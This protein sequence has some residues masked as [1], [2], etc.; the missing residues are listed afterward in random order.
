MWNY[1]RCDFHGLNEMFYMTPLDTGVDIFDDIDIDDSVEYFTDLFLQQVNDFIPNKTV[2]IRPRD[3]PWFNICVTI[4]N[5]SKYPRKW[6]Q[7]RDRLKRRSQKS[8][9][10]NH[11]TAY[12]TARREAKLAIDIAK[13]TYYDRLGK[14]LSD[15]SCAPKQYWS[16]MKSLYG[17]KVKSGIPSMIEGNEIYSTSAMQ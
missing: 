14:K 17:N 13:N 3:K 4:G 15:P 16:I 2:Y 11:I 7:V 6:L 1:D 12:K 8:R 10:P 9:N 5:I